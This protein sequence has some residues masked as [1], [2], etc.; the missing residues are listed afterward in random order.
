MKKSEI[1][2]MGVA[3]IVLIASII[4]LSSLSRPSHEKIAKDIRTAD[5]W[6]TY[7]DSEPNIH[8]CL[9]VFDKIDHTTQVRIWDDLSYMVAN[10][11]TNDDKARIKE[12]SWGYLVIYVKDRNNYSNAAAF[13]DDARKNH[14]G[15]EQRWAYILLT[16]KRLEE[17]SNQYL[18][19]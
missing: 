1:T 4:T 9:N 19:R 11:L 10:I 5:Q 16:D 8:R 6:V 15:E 18:N 3:I 14:F 7:C 12:D 17:L 2:I 13:W